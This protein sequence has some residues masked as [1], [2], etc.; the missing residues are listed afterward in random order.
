MLISPLDSLY[1]GNYEFKNQFCVDKNFYTCI[2]LRVNNI[3]FSWIRQL[4]RIV[5]QDRLS[6]KRKS[7]FQL[8]SI[9]Y[10]NRSRQLSWLFTVS[11]CIWQINSWTKTIL[12]SHVDIDGPPAIYAQI[13]ISGPT[14]LTVLFC[15][16]NKLRKVFLK[17][18]WVFSQESWFEGHTLRLCL[19]VFFRMLREDIGGG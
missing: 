13:N 1:S 4:A 18:I 2:M 10:T 14:D 15:A 11:Y 19:L 3:E 8:V 6:K 5:G 16:C 7:S 12:A 17:I 9:K